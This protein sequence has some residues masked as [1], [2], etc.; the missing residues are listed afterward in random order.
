MFVNFLL[1]T[2]ELIVPNFYPPH[3]CLAVCNYLIIFVPG[4]TLQL[5]ETVGIEAKER[6]RKKSNEKILGMIS[7][8][9]ST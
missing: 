6:K 2:G 3:L 5:R 4:I 1:R 8:L 7:E 9:L